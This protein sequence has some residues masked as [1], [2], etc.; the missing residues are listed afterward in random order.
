M[1]ELQLVL[2]PAASEQIMAAR[3]RKTIIYQVSRRRRRRL[4]LLCPP[5]SLSP[6]PL[7]PR[8]LFCHRVFF[9]LAAGGRAKGEG[10]RRG[11]VCQMLEIRDTDG[12][13]FEFIE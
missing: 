8:A 9:A 12:D 4:L 11:S 2:P 13:I 5:P 1:P 7:T 6:S 3:A 10:R